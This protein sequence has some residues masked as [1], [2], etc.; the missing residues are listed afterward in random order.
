MKEQYY[1]VQAF[2]T[3]WGACSQNFTTLPEA[4]KTKDMLRQKIPHI[5]L[6]IIKIIKQTIIVM[7]TE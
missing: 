6:R 2:Q 7:G 5:P 3:H 4:I 1:Q